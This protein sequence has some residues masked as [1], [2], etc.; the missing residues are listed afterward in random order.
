MKAKKV[1]GTLGVM[2]VMFILGG[3]AATIVSGLVATP[4]HRGDSS[5]VPPMPVARDTQQEAE[6]STQMTTEDRMKTNLLGLTKRR[7]GVFVNKALRPEFNN[8]VVVTM[9]NWGFTTFFFNWAC[10]AKKLGLDYLV[11]SMDSKLHN[12]LGDSRS[13][14][15]DDVQGKQEWGTT[16]YYDM[17][18]HK[19]EAIQYL[20]E[21][22]VNVLF[23]DADNVIG[24]VP[25]K[26]LSEM[27]E[28]KYDVLIQA[29][30]PS[31][32]SREDCP[33][34]WKAGKTANGGFYYFSAKRKAQTSAL[35][36]RAVQHCLKKPREK[37][38]C[39]DQQAVNKAIVELSIPDPEPPLSDNSFKGM[40]FCKYENGGSPDNENSL[41][42]CVMDPQMH[43]AG[44]HDVF[45]EKL[46]S[47]HAN[48]ILK[49][50]AKIE[51]L[52]RYGLWMWVGETCREEGLQ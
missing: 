27:A 51:K 29:D 3:V 19:I 28:G 39:D 26:L 45:P 33:F 5:V 25:E 17:G 11:L 18:C 14:L 32:V 48:W 52:S 15:M 50:D 49:A 6:S 9:A 21:L 43:P 44:K 41:Q 46:V 20:V 7:A 38:C 34:K 13:L 10:F 37:L 4:Q 47:L 16:A 30:H 2:V 1:D 36:K 12:F 22:G 31:C 42:F 35:L 40:E 23:S 24:R 8:T